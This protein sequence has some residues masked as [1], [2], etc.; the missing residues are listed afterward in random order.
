MNNKFRFA[1]WNVNS[2][3]IRMDLLKKFVEQEQPDI[4]CIQEVKAKKEDFPFN[5]IQQLGYPHIALYSQAGYNGVA[6]ISKYAL[7]EIEEFNWVGKKDARHI[8]A[9]IFNDIEI[10]NI[11][12]CLYLSSGSISLKFYI[13]KAEFLSARFG[14]TI[15]ILL[16]FKL[17]VTIRQLFAHR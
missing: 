10:H 17:F 14:Q 3:R 8:K 9:K 4:I 6:I 13:K 7:S 16:L 5:E 12:N 2:I 1:T 11:Y 15:E